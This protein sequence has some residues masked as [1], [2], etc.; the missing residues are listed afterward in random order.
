[1][2]LAAVVVVVEVD[3]GYRP[4]AAVC[5]VAGIEASPKGKDY[6]CLWLVV[7]AVWR[8]VVAVD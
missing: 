3:I 8:S 1:M 7:A 4:E 6:Y 2:A 5:V